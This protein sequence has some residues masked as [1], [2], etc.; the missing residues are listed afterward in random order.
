MDPWCIIH[1]K[2]IVRFTVI[3][4]QLNTMLLEVYDFV[5]IS[6]YQLLKLYLWKFIKSLSTGSK[7]LKNFHDDVIKWKRFPCYWPFV[8]G[9]HRSPVNFPHKGQWRG[10]LMFS[11]ICAW[12]NSWAN[13]GDAGDLRRHLTHHGVIV[14]ITP[15]SYMCWKPYSSQKYASYF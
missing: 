15:H 13:S 8:R 3:F 10:A 1:F 12:T 11:L 5:M 4:I 14:M 9:I 2:Q 6:I 7:Y